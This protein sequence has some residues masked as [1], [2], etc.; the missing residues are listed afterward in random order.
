M[1]KAIVRGT[2]IENITNVVSVEWT[3]PAGTVAVDDPNNE[4]QMGGSFSNGVFTNVPDP[5]PTAAEQRTA[6]F[7]ADPTRADLLDKLRNATLA[8]IDTYVDNNVANLVDART[9]LKK[10]I[11]VLALNVQK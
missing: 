11:K 5:V 1:R 3:P 8:Q 7:V 9:M 4:A 6:L 10:I 2:L